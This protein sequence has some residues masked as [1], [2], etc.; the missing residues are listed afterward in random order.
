MGWS[1]WRPWDGW[2][3]FT[4]GKGMDHWVPQWLW[5]SC[6]E[7]P[8]IPVSWCALGW[9]PRSECGQDLW[10]ASNL[11]NPAKVNNYVD[12][13][14]LHNMATCLAGDSCTQW[15][16]MQ[17]LGGGLPHEELQAASRTQ[18]QPL[19]DEHL[20]AKVLTSLTMRKWILPTKWVSLE[21]DSS[22]V[23]P[24]CE[25]PALPDTSSVPLYRT[26]L[27]HACAPDSQQQQDNKRV[28]V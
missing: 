5:Q 21:V 14:K 6:K 9:L 10:L 24:P 11:Y 28:L 17:L 25:N 26:Q 16:S 2:M 13:I 12:V 23:Q 18:R 3:Y 19:A 15:Y 8:M 1:S 20:K 27:S 22:P 4:F 7:V